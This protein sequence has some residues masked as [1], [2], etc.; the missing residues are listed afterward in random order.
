[1]PYVLMGG[2]EIVL[3]I[4]CVIHCIRSGRNSSWIFLIV[5][6]P[7]VGCAAYLVIEV[8]PGIKGTGGRKLNVSELELKLKL[9]DTHENRYYLAEAYRN[10]GQYEKALQL[11]DSC[12]TGMYRDDTAL[13]Y[14]IAGLHFLLKENRKAGECYGEILL[15]RKI[16]K[17]HLVTYART[18]EANDETEKCLKIYGELDAENNIEGL[19]Y[20]GQ[21]LKK[22]GRS[23]EARQKWERIIDLS[24]TMP[25]FVYRAN[26]DSIESARY[27]LRS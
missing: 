1:M 12:R 19:L 9:S 2:A 7:L 25:P 15:Q 27:E 16:E 22:L 13:L 17:K 26:R 23:A 4:I 24:Q 8:L 14:Q 6:V 10:A 3:Q 5:F 20:Y 11:L 21:F 18:L